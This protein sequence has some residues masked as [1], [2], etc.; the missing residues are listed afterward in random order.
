MSASEVREMGNTVMDALRNPE[1]PRADDKW[2]IGEIIRQFWILAR[3]T[4]TTSSQ[5]RFIKGFDGWFQGLVTQ[6][7]DRDKPCLRD[8]DS[9]IALRRNT[10]GL[11]ACWP[12]LHLGMAIPREVLEHPTIQR[13]ALFCTD[14]IS[15]DNDILSYNKEQACGN[16]EHN[17]VTIAM[18]QLHLD[19]Q[20]AMNWAAGYHA[21]TMRQFKEVYETIPHW[22]REVDLDVETYV[23]GMGNWGLEDAGN[24]TLA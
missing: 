16:D 20:G 17:I 3:K 18:N 22:G 14:M 15:I 13:L 21:A 6:A 19:V 12:I 4:A 5:Q 24:F 9:Y 7:E 2:V 11:E 8:I 23:D 10:S 1:V